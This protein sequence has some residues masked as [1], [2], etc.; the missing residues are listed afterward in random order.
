MKILPS[1]F[2]SCAGKMGTGG[3]KAIEKIVVVVDS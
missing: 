3:I 2:S 1:I